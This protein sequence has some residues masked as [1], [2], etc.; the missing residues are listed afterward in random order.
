MGNRIPDR[1]YSPNYRPRYSF[2]RETL[3]DKTEDVRLVRWAKLLRSAQQGNKDDYRQLLIELSVVLRSHVEE[4]YPQVS[5]VSEFVK[6]VLRKLHQKRR[7]FTINA[8]FLPWIYTIVQKTAE[9]L[10]PKDHAA[11]KHHD[12]HL[13]SQLG[14][15]LVQNSAS[16]KDYTSVN[17]DASVKIRAK[18]P[19][20]YDR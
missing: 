20:S 1:F 2:F 17:S 13:M 10:Y 15:K 18:E 14:I 3:E 16:S 5:H 4:Q 7:S 19:E 12:H 6:E 8:S 9:Q 11:A